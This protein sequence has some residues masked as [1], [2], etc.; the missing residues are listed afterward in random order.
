MKMGARLGCIGLGKMGTPLSRNLLA[1]GHAVCGFDV[2]GRRMAQL[3]E[4]GGSPLRER[5]GGRPSARTSCSPCCFAPNRSRRAP[6]GLRA[7]P[8]RA[9]R[10][11]VLVEMSTMKPRMVRRTGEGSWKQKGW[12][13]SMPPCPA[14]C[15]TSSR[16]RWPT[17]WG[18]KEEVFTRIKPHHRASGGKASSI[19][20]PHGTGCSMKLVTNLIVNAGVALLA[21]G[22]APR[23]ERSGLAPGRDHVLPALG[24]GRRAFFWS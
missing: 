1:D 5:A 13:W 12:R 7:S 19:P 8:P 23:G 11:L 15:R 6:S 18:G 22:P 24:S 21:E 17:W 14:R 4:A 20:A 9:R 16:G 2:D 10:G 3:R